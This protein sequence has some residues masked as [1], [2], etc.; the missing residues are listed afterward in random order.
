M[1][2]LLWFLGLFGAGLAAMGLLTYPLWLALEPFF[3]FEFHRVGSRFAMLVLL[4]GFVLVAR[5]LGLADRASL[6]YGLPRPRFLRET[7]TGFAL[8]VVLMALVVGAMAMLD[9]RMIK[10]WVEWTPALLV[11]VVLSA[12]LSG[13]AVGLIE[14]TFFR[15]AMHTAIG[16]ESGPA[17]AIASTALLYSAVHFLGRHEVAA[18]D[19]HAGSGL[20]LLTGALTNFAAPLA[21]AD[22]FLCLLAVG[23]LLG[24]V[25][26]ITGS[27]AACIGLHAGWVTVIAVTRKLSR[28]D[29][30]EPLAFLLSNFDGMVGWLVLGWTVL[31]GIFLVKYYR[32]R[33]STAGGATVPPPS[34][35]RRVR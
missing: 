22:A 19:V 6:G 11:P 10:P 21:I 23:I 20:D 31:T 29:R 8:G 28:P 26:H 7:A 27:I 4:V 24:I 12:M 5:R 15:G 3:D 14:E 16:R 30:D 25:R 9:L 1:R 32:R 33:A 17:L 18:E 2:S 13:L 34:G 35:S